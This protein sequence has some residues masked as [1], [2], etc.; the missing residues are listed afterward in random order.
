MLAILPTCSALG[1]PVYMVA[2]SQWRPSLHAEGRFDHTALGSSVVAMTDFTKQFAATAAGTAAF[3]LSP[4]ER[5]PALYVLSSERSSSSADEP[6]T[7]D[8]ADTTGD[9]HIIA[10][11]PAL[12]FAA[13]DGSQRYA[14]VLNLG[15]GAALKADAYFERSSSTADEPDTYDGA[16]HHI[17]SIEPALMSAAANG[18]LR[19]AQYPFQSF[20]VWLRSTTFASQRLTITLTSA[21][22]TFAFLLVPCAPVHKLLLLQFLPMV[23]ATRSA[24]RQHALAAEHD[25][26]TVTKGIACSGATSSTDG[27]FYT[28][29]S[30]D[31]TGDHH[32]T[33]AEPSLMLATVDGSQPSGSSLGQVDNATSYSYV[34]RYRPSIVNIIIGLTS[35]FFLL[36]TLLC[37]WLHDAVTIV[38]REASSVAAAKGTTDAAV[39]AR[40]AMATRATSPKPHATRCWRSC[41]TN[42][43]LKPSDD[44]SEVPPEVSP[45]GDVPQAGDGYGNSPLRSSKRCTA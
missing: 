40:T 43:S 29:D 21:L 36:L 35:G 8:G 9:H 7:F 28:Y 31:T 16:D 39:T 22:G 11:E 38:A 4:K 18:S 14:P 26:G 30:V 37:A 45:S 42:H 27:E 33:A 15:N 1:L 24:M 34:L 25:V 3:P 19:S 23:G 10:N 17:I 20:S 13:A 44:I 32:I 41:T 12:L 2:C 5:P 6:D